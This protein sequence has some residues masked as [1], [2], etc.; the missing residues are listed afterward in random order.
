MNIKKSD[1]LGITLFLMVAIGWYFFY[2]KPHNE[3]L[4]SIMDC[5][6]EVDPEANNII[7]AHEVCVDRLKAGG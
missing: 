1:F 4:Y 7:W 5:T 6:M 2:I 3:A